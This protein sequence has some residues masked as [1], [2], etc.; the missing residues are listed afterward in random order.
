MKLMNV[1][2]GDANQSL[3][4][5]DYTSIAIDKLGATEYT[6]VH[7]VVDK[8][9]SVDPFK[10]KLEEMLIACINSCKKSP[11]ALN[12]LIRTTA[13]N[14]T[15]QED[16][17]ELHGFTLLDTLKTDQFKGSIQPNGS[18]PLYAATNEALGAV[19]D[20]GTKLYDKEFLC[21]SIVFVI[22]DGDDNASRGI[23]PSTVKETVS[24][25]R[26]K[27]VLESIRI[28]LIGI[29]DQDKH[30]QGR[31]ES[32]RKEAALD[33]YISVGDVTEGK[34]AKLAQFISQSVSSQSQALGS[35]GPSQP[36]DYKF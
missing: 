13:F 16:I 29:N 6:I 11:R 12:L 4:G 27:E 7:I 28:I 31:L 26:K 33:E 5:F 15:P 8:T 10:D 30:F 24:D 1:D 18:T 34:L 23:Y 21:N 32:F 3:Q 2:A 25:I 9:G 17:E 14:A 35:G 36:V 20:Y 22:T 19:L